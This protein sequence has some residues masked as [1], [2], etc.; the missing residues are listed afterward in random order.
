MEEAH[1]AQH[2]R[3]LGE[4]D[5]VVADNFDPVDPGIAEVEKRTRQRLD[6]R[7]GQRSA[8]GLLH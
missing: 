3:R 1:S 6:T 7:F 8:D 4:L 2:V 5:V